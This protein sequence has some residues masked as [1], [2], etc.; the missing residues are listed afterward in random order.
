MPMQTTLRNNEP[1]GRSISVCLPTDLH[2]DPRGGRPGATLMAA[3]IPESPAPGPRLIPPPQTSSNA[4][5]NQTSQPPFSAISHSPLNTTPSPPASPAFLTD[6]DPSHANL[7][8]SL[9]NTQTRKNVLGEAVFPGWRD[10]AASA[11]LS[12]PEE[13]QKKD[14][15]GTQMWKLYSRTKSQLP[16]QERMENLT[17]RMMAMNLKRKEQERARFVATRLGIL[18][19]VRD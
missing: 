13:M 18:L 17:W 16:N 19:A 6:I 10:D 8:L 5:A 14:P 12:H 2:Q 3:A 7:A 1:P 15:L 11:D 4:N 9:D